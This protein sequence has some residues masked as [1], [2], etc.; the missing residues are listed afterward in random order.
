MYPNPTNGKVYISSD[1]LKIEKME[2]LDHTGKLV[3]KEENSNE[4][5]LSE[6]SD[7]LYILRCYTFDKFITSKIVLRH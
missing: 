6:L 4:L 5:D 1:N 7:G 2:V 3:L